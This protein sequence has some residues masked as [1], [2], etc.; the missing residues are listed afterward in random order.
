MLKNPKGLS[1]RKNSKGIPILRV[2][3]S[4]DPTRNEAWVNEMRPKASSDTMWKQEQE[5]DYSAVGGDLAVG[6]RLMLRYDDIVIKDPDWRINSHCSFD[7][8]LDY[9][10]S[11]F[12][13]LEVFGRDFDGIDYA[14]C[15]HYNRGMTPQEHARVIREMY[16][17]CAGQPNLL[18]TISATWSDPALFPESVAGGS[19]SKFSSFQDLFEQHGSIKMQKGLRGLDL[20]FRDMLLDA[21]PKEGPVRFKIWCPEPVQRLTPGTF[22]HG[23]PNLLWELLH[24]RMRERSAVVE[25]VKGPAEELVDAKNDAWDSA[26]YRFTATRVEPERDRE[27]EWGKIAAQI[28]RNNPRGGLDALIWARKKWEAGQETGELT[29]R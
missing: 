16:I 15:E 6:E 19:D 11:H 14:V 22:Q 24:L 17:P 12:T 3:Y 4:A 5:I 2:H 1:L 8:G 21:W 28:R 29:Y 7:A 26:K 18:E 25:H 10:K 23:C 27:E 9:G 13:A 20:R